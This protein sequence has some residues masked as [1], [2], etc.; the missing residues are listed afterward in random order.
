MIMI[1]TL[2]WWLHYAQHTFLYC[3]YLY[4]NFFYAEEQLLMFQKVKIVVIKI[5]FLLPQKQGNIQDNKKAKAEKER[6]MWEA[7]RKTFQFASL[8][9]YYCYFYLLVTC[10]IKLFPFSQE[11]KN[12]C[13]C[14][15]E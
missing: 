1:F 15:N 5:S 12:S 11:K 7:E 9:C 13:T 10:K 14:L 4:H 6:E 8:L 2:W 3:Y